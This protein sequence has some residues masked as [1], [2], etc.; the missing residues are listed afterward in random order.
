MISPINSNIATKN[1]IILK[2]N[3]KQSEINFKGPIGD[4]FLKT[5]TIENKELFLE[6]VLDKLSTLNGLSYSRTKKVLDALLSKVTILSDEVSK[7]SQKNKILQ[8][9]LEELKKQKKDL[10]LGSKAMIESANYT[11]IEKCIEIE[12]LENTIKELN[13]TK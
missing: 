2:Q 3:K 7:L 12:K 10:L 13:K 8:K 6:K 11:I 9:E 5:T 4:E 1:V